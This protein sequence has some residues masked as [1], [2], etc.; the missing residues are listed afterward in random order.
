MSPG[1]EIPDV[2]MRS[3]RLA[4]AMLGS[5]ALPQLSNSSISR[6]RPINQFSLRRETDGA[7]YVCNYD[8]S[9]QGT[10]VNFDAR[11]NNI[12]IISTLLSIS[13]AVQINILPVILHTR[14]TKNP[15]N[16][17]VTKNWYAGERHTNTASSMCTP[18]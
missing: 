13:A 5:L 7:P 12:L 4:L 3:S 8:E 11:L 16:W 6:R 14:N 15:Q 2:P 9:V 1:L 10:S 17:L 18:T